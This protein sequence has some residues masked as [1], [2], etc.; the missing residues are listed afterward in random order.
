MHPSVHSETAGKCPICG[1]DLV[2]VTHRKDESSKPSEFIVPVQRQQQI[3]VTY[4][5]VRRKHMQFD[6]RSVGTLE[7]DQQQI[8]DAYFRENAD[9]P[10]RRHADT[11]LP[12]RRLLE[13]V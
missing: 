13:C 9:T 3:G 7:V 4:A 8:F 12:W 11:S 5:E 1:M 10:T 2:P 6:I